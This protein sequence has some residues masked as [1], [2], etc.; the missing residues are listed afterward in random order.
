MVN[1]STTESKKSSFVFGSFIRNTGW[2]LIDKVFRLGLGLGLSIWIAR[3]LGPAPFGTLNYGLTIAGIFTALS[4]LG[5]NNIVVRNLIQQPAERNYI[6]GSAFLLRIAGSILL[7]VF[8]ILLVK[9]IHPLENLTQSIVA[10]AVVSGIF[11]S[12][13]IIA[14]WFESQLKSRY[15]VIAENAAFLLTSAIR[16]TL[17]W[18]TAP[19]IAFAWAFF[20]E[21]LLSSIALLIV[22]RKSG[23]SLFNW[24]PKLETS[25]SLLKDSWPLALSSVAIIIYMKSDVV[26]LQAL[27]GETSVGLYSAA[28]KFLEASY[29]IP[30]AITSSMLPSLSEDKKSNP[31]QYFRNF[32]TLTRVLAKMAI[33]ISLILCLISTPLIKLLFG[34]DYAPAGPVLGILIW[35]CVFAFLQRAQAPWIINENLMHFAMRRS[36]AGALIN[37]ALNFILIPKYGAVGAA[38]GTLTA[39]FLTGFIANLFSEKT[40]PIF[41]IQLRALFFLKRLT[42]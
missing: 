10:I 22:Y 7:S 9:S 34:V 15:T 20:I 38:F 39:F 33:V 35:T 21:A 42:P 26:M 17:I 16:L 37:I 36:F 18:T 2:L 40:R 25:K 30:A 5:L 6:L 19:L 3:Y 41:F 13:E 24:R 8:A 29:F 12:T 32:E 31:T 28:S 23:G 1:D 4:T 11:R 14:F 27:S